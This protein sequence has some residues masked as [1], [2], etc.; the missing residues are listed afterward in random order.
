M[1]IGTTVACVILPYLSTENLDAFTVSVPN[2]SPLAPLVDTDVNDSTL[3]EPTTTAVSARSIN[4]L[5]ATPSGVVNIT[6]PAPPV[7]FLVVIC[8]VAVLVNRPKVVMFANA[9]KSLSNP[10]ASV[11]PYSA[12]VD[13]KLAP[14]TL[15]LESTSTLE[16][17][18]VASGSL[19]L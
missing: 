6:L 4:G 7:R 10:C 11:I 9:V 15:P 2:G 3:Y 12:R 1:A 13:A 18:A 14:T 16:Y 8:P 17:K 5:D 19:A